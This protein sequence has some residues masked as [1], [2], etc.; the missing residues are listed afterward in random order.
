M[1]VSVGGSQVWL[2]AQVWLAH[3]MNRSTLFLGYVGLANAI[4]SIVLNLFGG[5]FADRLDRRR[6]LMVTQ[7]SSGLLLVLMAVLVHIGAAQPWHLLAISFSTGAV[8]AFDQPA[9]QA[10]LPD[11]VERKA[12]MSA[13]ALQGLVWQGT[14]IVGPAIGGLIIVWWGNAAAL[15]VSAAGYF[16]MLAVLVQLDLPKIEVRRQTGAARDIVDGLLFIKSNS[17]FSFLIAMT[18]FNSFFGMSYVWLMPIFAQ[19]ILK[20]GASGQ[21]MLLSM[22]GAGG[23]LIS[24]LLSVTGKLP[25]PTLFIVGGAMITGLSLTAFAITADRIGSFPLAM[26]LMFA[27]GLSSTAY[28]TGVRTSLQILVPRDMLGRVMGFY[29]MTWSL[30]PLGGMEAAFVSGII[31]APIAIAIGG[32][33]VAAFAAG[34]GLLNRRVR[35]LGTEIQRAQAGVNSPGKW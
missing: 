4:P 24:L 19:D 13:M 2:F 27:M 14:R 26:V 6:L 31:G 1:L 10:L 5:V 21:G 12:M 22:V 29:G 20:V 25:R 16:V 8:N 18:F 35:G 34:P 28:M 33:A 23:L 11:L 3:T 32:V 7:T 17:V 9:R 15:Y 30:T